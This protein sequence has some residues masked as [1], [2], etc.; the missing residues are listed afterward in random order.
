MTRHVFASAALL[1]AMI[2]MGLHAQGTAPDMADAI[3]VVPIDCVLAGEGTACTI[4]TERPV[5][6]CMAVDAA[7]APVA[8]S[9]GATDAGEILFQDVDPSRIVGLRCREV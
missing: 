8:N 1:A 7:G 4:R 6:F 2:P 9:T 3:D 5:T